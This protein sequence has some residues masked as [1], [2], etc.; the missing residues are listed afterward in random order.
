MINNVMNLLYQEKTFFIGLLLDHL[1]IVGISVLIATILGL[2]IGI[3][4]SEHDKYA[5]SIMNVINVLYTIPSIALLGILISITGIGNTTAII[6]LTIYA[7]LP[8]VRAVYTGIKNINPAILEAAYAMGSTEKQALFKVKL[9]LALPVIMSGLRNMVT[10]T[11]ALGG[12]ASFVGAGGLGVAIYRGIGSNNKAMIIAGSILVALLALICDFFLGRL[13]K[14]LTKNFRLKKGTK[15][16]IA[17]ILV[18]LTIFGLYSKLMTKPTIN[19]ATKP[20]TEGFILGQMIGN[21]VSEYTDYKVVVSPGVGGGTAN[22]HPA[23]VKGDFDLYPE[24]TGTVWQIIL[25]K[26]EKYDESKFDV[27]NL[28]YKNR[29]NLEFTTMFGFN[30]TYSIAVSKN[31]AEKYGLKT[32]SDLARVSKELTFG[33][34]YDF[35]VRED[36]YNGVKNAYGF[37]F[38]NTV[39]MDSGLKYPAMIAGK[40]DAMTVY[41]T[42][43]QL[44]NENIVVL[45]DDKGFYPS[46]EGGIVINRNSL[47]KYPELKEALDKLKGVLDEKSMTK[48]NYEVETEKKEPYDVAR[49][50]LIE[51]GIIKGN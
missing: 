5:Q 22:I 12:I 31:V 44:N 27:L 39:D 29:F 11:I 3:L 6:A 33:A 50:F 35:F 30:D 41:T 16:A 18:I 26:T 45:K 28:D 14:S 37:K 38:K 21:V 4:I 7:L 13:E 23:M 10:M 49:K 19:I 43:G 1:K 34:E 48:L 25:K 46:Y 36:G 9:P 40:I 47:K 42:D 15:I 17:S 8:M 51:K 20:V 24:Y 2:I 32:F